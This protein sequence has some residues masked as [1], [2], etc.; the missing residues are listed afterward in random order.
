MRHLAV[1]LMVLG[2]VACGGGGGGDG[3][4]GG[5]GGG[6]TQP[7]TVSGLLTY[8]RVPHF[9]SGGLNFGST[10]QA[11]VVG[12]TVQ[13]LAAS[14]SVLATTVSGADGRYSLSVPGNAQFRIRA[15]AERRQTGTPG[16][17]VRVQDNTRSGEP[18][19]AMESALI[20][21]AGENLVRNLNAPSGWTGSAYTQPRVAAPFAI[22]DSMRTA[23]QKVL[24]VAPNTAFPVLR[25]GWSPNNV[26]SD[27]FRPGLG[28]IITTFAAGDRIYVLG[29]ASSDTDE[30]DEHVLIH[31]WG[32]Y[33][34]DNLA[35]VD[36]PGGIHSL[37]FRLDLRVAFSEGWGN[38]WAGMALNDPMYRDT[39]RPG[40]PSDTFG[41]NLNAGSSAVE[42]WYSE[43]T[44]G[45]LLWDIYDADNSGLDQLSLGFGPIDAVLRGPQRT[46]PALT[47]IYTFLFHLKQQQPGSTAVLD[48]M[49]QARGIRSTGQDIWGTTETNNGGVTQALPIYLPLAVGGP[50]V[51]ACT[52]AT[53]SEYD[54][55]I[56]N[57]R[58][59]R[60]AIDSAG[61]YSFEA[62]GPQGSRP[63]L[64][65]WTQGNVATS[66]NASGV[67][68]LQ[69]NLQPGERVLEV[70]DIRNLDEPVA[71]NV[72]F[73]VTARRVQ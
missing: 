20:T 36:S 59:L 72:C 45:G 41:F 47:S 44:V 1:L 52:R 35:R 30:Y 53:S 40:V 64:L 68:T 11:P 9:S 57:R 22:L 39:G 62:Q 7:I 70:Y 28:E 24:S 55:R 38:A 69:R 14:G 46:T 26:E 23:K 51:E 37:A 19:Y 67:A 16:W 5:G 54:N 21:A 65:L 63:D 8:D 73:A 50:S 48:A 25:I 32:H 43:A 66:S 27:E 58:F 18:V 10:R 12:V 2:L 71:G 33:Y 61:T 17:D 34:E 13:A 15:L 31:E 4:G 56:G 60:V 29:D 6:G 3:G 42:G 49:A